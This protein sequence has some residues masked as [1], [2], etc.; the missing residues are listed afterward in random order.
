M[1]EELRFLGYIVSKDGIKVDPS[2]IEAI[3]MWPIP[4]TI[5]KVR[6]FYGLASFYRRL[7]KNFSTLMSLIM[8][9]SNKGRLS[10]LKKHNKPLN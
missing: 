8:Y 1:Q 3:S 7:I 2:K 4:K 5:T 9:V 10:G 6:S